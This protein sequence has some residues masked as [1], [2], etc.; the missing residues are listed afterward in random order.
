MAEDTEVPEAVADS[1]A[2]QL[3]EEF[4][5]VATNLLERLETFLDSQQDLSPTGQSAA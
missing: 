5:A 4:A 3:W 2:Y 1:P